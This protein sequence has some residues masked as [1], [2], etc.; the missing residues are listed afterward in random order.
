MVYTFPRCR[1]DSFDGGAGE[2]CG[3]GRGGEGVHRTGLGSRLLLPEPGRSLEHRRRSFLHL[4][5]RFA[6]QPSS[7]IF[8]YFI[9]KRASQRIEENYKEVI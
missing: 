3:G 6:F 9:S 8:K 1:K 4:C 5:E 7:E 2:Q